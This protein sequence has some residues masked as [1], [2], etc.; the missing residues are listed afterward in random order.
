MESLSRLKMEIKEKEVQLAVYPWG[1]CN[2]RCLYCSYRGARGTLKI[3]DFV[4]VLKFLKKVEPGFSKITFLGGEPTLKPRLLRAYFEAA[5]INAPDCRLFLF[6][7]GLEV[8][9]GVFRIL[10]EFNVN[11]VLSIDGFERVNYSQ[12]SRAD[13]KKYSPLKIAEKFLSA[14][15][16]SLAFSLTVTPDNAAFLVSNLKKMA[17]LG[18]SAIGWN[19]DYAASW[20]DSDLKQ[21]KK[22]IEGERLFY[23]KLLRAGKPYRIS[24]CYELMEE[25]GSGNKSSCSAFSLF[26]DGKIYACDKVFSAPLEKRKKAVLSRDN[27]KKD[28]KKFFSTALKAGFEDR[29]LI[30]RAGLYFYHKFV[31]CL[32][33]KALEESLSVSLKTAALIEREKMKSLRLFMKYGLFRKLHGL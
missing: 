23:L 32:E 12:R 16:N 8:E 33:G 19:A 21:L 9:E 26:P 5:G 31:K 15:L 7:N 24:N 3:K 11:V 6:T 1:D 18:A 27:F 28:R 30:C 20:S 2:M 22:Q 29:G 25:I 10:K 14:G 4:S 13:K 17:L